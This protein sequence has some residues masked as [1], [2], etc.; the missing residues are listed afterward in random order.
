MDTWA[1]YDAEREALC[2]DLA[3]LGDSQW[4]TQSLCGEWKVR[5]VVAHLV[6]ECDRKTAAML[7]GFLRSGLDPNRYI[8]REALVAGEASPGSLLNQL[9]ATIGK[10]KTPPLAKPMAM[11][12]DTVCH[13]GDIR[14]PLGINRKPTEETL[15]AV[16]EDMKSANFPLGTRRRITGLRLVATDTAWSTGNGPAVEGP[17][18]SLILMMAGRRGALEG[19][20]GE[21]LPLLTSRI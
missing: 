19:L 4:E 1:N 9:R 21:G 14:L 11:L 2:G 3:G 15:L 17:V 8:A 13:S 20:T 16:A 10:R 7:I 5:H 18:E 6:A 12:I